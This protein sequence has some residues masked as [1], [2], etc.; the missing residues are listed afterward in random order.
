LSWWSVENMLKNLM[1]TLWKLYIKKKKE[2]IGNHKLFPLWSRSLQI[3]K[4]TSW[5]RLLEVYTTWVDM[6]S[7]GKF[8]NSIITIGLTISIFFFLN[9]DW[10]NLKIFSRNFVWDWD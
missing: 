2:D 4:S 7:G 3:R 1:S 6:M 10:F 8:W 5:K 9:M